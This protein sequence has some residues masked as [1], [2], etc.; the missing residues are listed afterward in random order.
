ML[1]FQRPVERY[2]FSQSMNLEGT[3]SYT[4]NIVGNEMYNLLETYNR[5][6][7]CNNRYEIPRGG[8][9]VGTRCPNNDT[10]EPIPL[11]AMIASA[12]PACSPISDSKRSARDCSCFN[13]VDH[14]WNQ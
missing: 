3:L 2:D 6:H 7:S 5:I 13:S 4:I 9:S 12:A 8:E 10:L 14:D 1:V 11:L